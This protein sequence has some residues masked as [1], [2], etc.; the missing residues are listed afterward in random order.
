MPDILHFST[1]KG[2]NFMHVIFSDKCNETWDLHGK[3]AVRLCVLVC[4][5]PLG[6]QIV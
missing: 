5:L 6:K 3:A 1:N 2:K 4:F